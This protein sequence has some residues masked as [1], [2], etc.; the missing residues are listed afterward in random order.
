MVKSE[1]CRG[2]K[3]GILKSEPETKKCSDL[4]EKHICDRQVY[5]RSETPR[6]IIKFFEIPRLG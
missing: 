1:T 3:T 5:T 4:I 2:A 6:P